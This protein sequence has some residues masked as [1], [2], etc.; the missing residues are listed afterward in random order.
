MPTTPLVTDDQPRRS[1]R[2]GRRKLIALD[3]AAKV[4]AERGA[5]AA[6]FV[7]VASECGLAVS[8]LQYYFGSREDMLVAAFRHASETELATL[9]GE[10]TQ[11]E[12]PWEKI[13]FLIEDALSGYIPGDDKGPLWIEAWRFGLRD[14]EM[15]ADVQRDYATWQSFLVDAVNEGLTN[16]RFVMGFDADQFAIL[17]LALV[18]GIGLRLAV[19]DP[20]VRI[21]EASSIIRTSLATLLNVA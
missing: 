6:R 1:R 21:E 17:A 19:A 15:R 4:I 8:T 14:E 20:L 11:R 7:D 12:D 16:E 10:L 2:A 5:D 9:A 13:V 3:A 18:D